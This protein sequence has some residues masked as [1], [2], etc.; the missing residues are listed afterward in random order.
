MLARPSGRNDLHGPGWPTWWRANQAREPTCWA[1]RLPLASCPMW[2]SGGSSTSVVWPT[3]RACSFGWGLT[4]EARRQWKTMVFDGGDGA[5]VA[6]DDGLGWGDEA[7]S[8]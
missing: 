1:S 6:G 7:W 2:C 3:R 5:P 4:G 8:N